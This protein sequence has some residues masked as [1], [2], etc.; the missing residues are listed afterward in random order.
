MEFPVRTGWQWA[1]TGES[2]GR[3]LRYSSSGRGRRSFD[4]QAAAAEGRTMRNKLANDTRVRLTV[5]QECERLH[6]RLAVS[7]CAARFRRSKVGGSWQK[8]GKTDAGMYDP[9]R[10]CA[11]GRL[12]MIKVASAQYADHVI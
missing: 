8:T 3:P 2:Q 6:T 7:A 10:G 12:N 5:V 1:R 11:V 9:C 4:A